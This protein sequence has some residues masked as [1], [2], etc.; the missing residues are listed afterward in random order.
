MKKYI[1]Y[2]LALISLI[3]CAACLT[4][5]TVTKGPQGTGGGGGLNF[6]GLGSAQ[7]TIAALLPLTG[8]SGGVRFG[9]ETLAGLK[10]AIENRPP[11]GPKINVLAFDTK[12]SPQEAARLVKEIA[13]QKDILAIVGPL[14]SQEAQEAALEA[15]KNRLPMVTISQRVGLSDVGS[16]IFRVF[17]TPKHQA[18]TVARYALTV[19]N[20]NAVGILF[21]DDAYGR[22]MRDYFTA[23]VEKHGGTV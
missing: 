8:D 7:G 19:G 18:E 1:I 23:E 6:S 2:P 9:H 10:L 13:A 4:T 17:L 14:M 22:S 16:H 5:T 21:P 15:E 12:G 3:V 20:H 11:G